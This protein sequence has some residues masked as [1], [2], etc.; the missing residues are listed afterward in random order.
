[1][2]CTSTVR[3]SYWNLGTVRC[4]DFIVVLCSYDVEHNSVRC[5]SICIR[6]D[7]QR[8]YDVYIYIHNTYIHTYI[9]IYV[10][11]Y[12][13]SA[14]TYIWT[15][16]CLEGHDDEVDHTRDNLHTI[17]SHVC[18]YVFHEQKACIA[19]FADVQVICVSLHIWWA[20]DMCA[21]DDNAVDYVCHWIRTRFSHVCVS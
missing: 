13:C 21:E 16:V 20:E 17:K 9:Y 12:I 11:T 8:T 1:M 14:Y 15:Y 3:T 2:K 6:F 18:Q 10:H 19:E 7:E 4:I 5:I